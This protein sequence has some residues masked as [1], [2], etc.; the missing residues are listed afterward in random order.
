MS[1]KDEVNGYDVFEH[2]IVTSAE[3]DQGQQEAD[4]E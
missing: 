3:P 4:D 1:G 2:E